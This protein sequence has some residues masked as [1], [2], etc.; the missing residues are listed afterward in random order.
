[1]VKTIVPSELSLFW[2]RYCFFDTFGSDKL[3]VRP[4]HFLSFLWA[5]T[6]LYF[7]RTI[8]PIRNYFTSCS[9]FEKKKKKK[10]LIISHTTKVLLSFILL[11]KFLSLNSYSLVHI[12][13]LCFH[14]HAVFLFLLW[15]LCDLPSYAMFCACIISH[16]TAK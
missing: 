12:L 7:I 10:R 1:M 9:K 4:I 14:S 11:C 3:V 5:L 16:T 8:L 13:F 15:V 2:S 6:L